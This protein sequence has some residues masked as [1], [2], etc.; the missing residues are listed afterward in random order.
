MGRPWVGACLICFRKNEEAHVA[1]AE[2]VGEGVAGGEV[3]GL[4]GFAGR[5]R[6]L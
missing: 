5:C 3:E 6:P 4:E 1:G 2:P